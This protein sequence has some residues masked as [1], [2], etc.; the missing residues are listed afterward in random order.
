MYVKGFVQGG[1]LK[2]T[3]TGGDLPGE[4]RAAGLMV[5]LSTAPGCAEYMTARPEVKVHDT[6]NGERGGTMATCR[7]IVGLAGSRWEAR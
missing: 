3:G 6:G 4:L 5:A 2:Q 7:D 1:E